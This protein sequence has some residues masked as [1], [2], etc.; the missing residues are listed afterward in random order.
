M[1]YRSETGR[2][3]CLADATCTFTRWQHFCV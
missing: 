3:C 2:R 1:Y